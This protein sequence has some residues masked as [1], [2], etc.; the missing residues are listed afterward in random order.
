MVIGRDAENVSEEDAL[1]Y[2]AAYT[3]GNDVSAR[4]Y[5]R[6]AGKASPVPQWSFSKSFDKYTPLGP[7]LVSSQLLGAADNL[8][9]K[10]IVN[11]EV[12]QE[13]NTSGL[14]FGGRKLVAFCSQGQILQRGYQVRPAPSSEPLTKCRNARVISDEARMQPAVMMN[15]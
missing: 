14:Y 1:D 15:Q 3:A 2:E 10:T 12:R 11:G 6:E 9:L 13:S 7:C 5:Q 8:S 4:D